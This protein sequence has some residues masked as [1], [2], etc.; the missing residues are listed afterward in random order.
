MHSA[1]I[2][3]Y[4]GPIFIYLSSL[5]QSGQRSISATANGTSSATD[6][7]KRKHKGHI[8]VLL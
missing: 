4:S 8:V 5:G 3:I 7:I 1:D 6:W 2:N